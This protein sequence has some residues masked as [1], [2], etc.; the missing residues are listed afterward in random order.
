MPFGYSAPGHVTMFRIMYRPY[1]RP[2]L[3][4]NTATL[5]CEKIHSLKKKKPVYYSW[6]GKE[7]MGSG[8]SRPGLHVTSAICSE[9]GIPTSYRCCKD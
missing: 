8:A 4:G 3:A 9:K 5:H 6:R 7:T 2:A 1:Q